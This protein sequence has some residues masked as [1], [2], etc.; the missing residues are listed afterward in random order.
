M[1]D[2]FERLKAAL[3]AS[4]A[5]ERELGSGG[6]ATVY[7]AEDLKHHRKVAVKVLRPE[8]AVAIG[9][10]RFF[11]EI[12]IAARLQH[13]HVLPLLD[14]GI[15]EERPGDP[16]GRPYYVMPFV[17][18]ESLRDRLR[19][20]ELPVEDAVRILIEVVD[21]L[22]YAHSQGVVHRDI[23]P[24]NV[25]LSG[26][27]ALVMD[28]GVAKAVSDAAGDKRMTETGVALGT[29]AYMA[30]EQA[31]AD[32]HLDHR[33]DIYAVGVLGYELLTG[34]PPF[35]GA[36]PQE[37]L[38]AQVTRPAEPITTHRPTIPPALAGILMKCLEKRPAD[39][40]Q[41]AEVLM[42]QLEAHAALSQ[43][44]TMPVRTTPPSPAG[45][46]KRGVPSW[47]GWA[48]AGALVVAGAVALSLRH[49]EPELL[50]L[51][52]RTA[53]ALAPEWEIHPSLSPDG[54]MLAYTS[55]GN[56]PPR[57]LLHQIGGGNPVVVS[58]AGFG[59][60]FSPDGT[61]LLAVTPRGL[62][63]MPALGGQSRVVATTTK[64][65]NWSPDGRAIVY[66]AGDTLWVQAADSSRRTPIATGW[67]L[68]SPSWSSDGRWIAYVEG[69]SL[70]HRNGNLGASGIRVVPSGG[71]TPV[72][73]T[74][75]S[76]LNT[77]PIW[78][79]GRPALLYISDREGGR[80]IYEV[81][82]TSRGV[83]RGD[84]ARLTT[85][86][87]VEGITISSDGRRLAWSQFRETANVWSLPIPAGDSI[88]L[89]RA[90]Q[91]TTGTQS[92]ESLVVSPDGEWLYYDSDRAGNSD[93]YRRRLSGGS[94][95]QLTTD[96]SADFSPAVSPDGREVAFHSLRTGNRDVFVMPAAGGE[97]VQV[98]RSP[99][100]D[101]NPTWSPDGRQL[102][103]DQQ[104]NPDQGL[105]ITR[106]AASGEW[107]SPDPFPHGGRA[108]RPRWSPD[109]RWISFISPEGVNVVEVG[110]DRSRLLLASRDEV[111]PATWTAWSDDGRTILFA[112]SDSLG[113]FRIIA[114]PLAGRRPA[115][116]IAYADVPGR[117]FHRHGIAV[118]R[119]RV[120]FPLVE[121]N[122]DVWVAEIER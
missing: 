12:E 1:A 34:Q 3:T 59:A 43:E 38:V 50:R 47:L 87:D 4:Y 98:T 39:R 84:P 60:A 36:T 109:G 20:G 26:R 73:V 22:A 107:T 25:L 110:S 8:L 105:W 94:T 16:N 69:N 65:G 27:H 49:S 70:F 99:E 111:Y 100:Q 68:H 46:P 89:S 75:V 64:W 18:G 6:M 93:I 10:D 66:P 48:G 114:I 2:N 15:I 82:L 79:P 90:T 106:R 54:K 17:D 5:L 31:V 55:V 119:G 115:T 88:P 116:T 113:V 92:I 19:R 28:F 51:G 72:G 23:K 86:L 11:R 108:A 102:A 57:L 122:S 56:A 45:V 53:V 103:F 14:S 41:S 80:D 52:K 44:T 61:R 32:P 21:A 97:A 77:S 104:R 83:P 13:P 63:I 71:G 40:W 81:T 85:G 95:E 9:S 30:P 74:R 42:G 118:S 91:V 62:E 121:R 76:G 7:L 101:Y 29:P 117:Q 33:V 67:D 120:F 78:L 112:R 37:V 35:R 58:Q 24:D 96:P